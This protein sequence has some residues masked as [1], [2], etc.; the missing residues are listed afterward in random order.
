MNQTILSYLHL[1]PTPQSS[2]NNLFP[3]PLNTLSINFLTS[4][5]FFTFLFI[6]PTHLILL[7]PIII[8]PHYLLYYIIIINLNILIIIIKIHETMSFNN[9]FYFM[10]QTSILLNQHIFYY[11]VYTLPILVYLMVFLVTLQY[12]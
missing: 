1:I 8:I 6:Y 7:L 2:F 9:L 10:V 5:I 12:I 11:S 4:L 3:S